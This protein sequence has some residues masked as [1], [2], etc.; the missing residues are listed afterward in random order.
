MNYMEQ[1]EHPLP[2]IDG[3]LRRLTFLIGLRQEIY[4]CLMALASLS[5]TRAEV[6]MQAKMVEKSLLALVSLSQMRAEVIIQAKMVKESLRKSKRSRSGGAALF[7]C[8]APP[9][10]V[11]WATLT[12]D[13]CWSGSGTPIPV[14]A[15]YDLRNPKHGVTT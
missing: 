5:Q 11:L 3:K 1:E 15:R 9:G 14:P 7:W 10:Y 8:Q 6:F 4:K 12:R 2:M 13:R